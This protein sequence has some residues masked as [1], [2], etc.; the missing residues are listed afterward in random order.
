MSCSLRQ[1]RIS[2]EVLLGHLAMRDR[3]LLH[4]LIHVDLLLLRHISVQVVGELEVVL[5]RVVLLLLLQNQPVIFAQLCARCLSLQSLEVL[6]ELH[7]E[8]VSVLAVMR[9]I[10]ALVQGT[11]N[12]RRDAVIDFLIAL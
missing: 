10:F 7:A 4:Q 9:A 2:I 6:W 12:L 3:R 1:I 5:G 11:R 8:G